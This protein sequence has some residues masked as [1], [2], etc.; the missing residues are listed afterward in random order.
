MWT[1]ADGWVGHQQNVHK[2][3]F[4][5]RSL[6]RSP[7]P[8][9]PRASGFQNLW[10]EAIQ[11]KSVFTNLSS[12]VRSSFPAFPTWGDPALVALHRQRALLVWCGGLRGHAATEHRLE[13]IVS[14]F[15]QFKAILCIINTSI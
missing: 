8:P 7:T 2:S 3:N 5:F 13:N 12:V 14:L 4:A 9:R 15:I 6:Y 1:T 11:S 10:P